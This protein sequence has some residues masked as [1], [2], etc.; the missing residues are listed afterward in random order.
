MRQ[1]PDAR[2]AA[3]PARPGWRVAV[4]GS[5]VAGL[6]AAWSLRQSDQPC[7][8]TLFEAGAHFGGHAH[9]QT[10]TLEGIRHGVDTGF[11]VYNE[12][13][14]PRLIRLFD[15]LAVATAPSDMSFSVQVHQGQ[16]RA[17]EWSGSNLATVFAQKRNLVRPRFW[18]ML[19]DIVRF[20]RLATALA[21][22]QGDAGMTQSV[23]DFLSQHGFGARFRDDYLLPMIGCIWSCPLDQML[24]FPMATLIRFCH[25][26]GLLQV[27]NRPQWYTVQGGSRHYVD[28]IVA[29][30]DDARLHTPVLA[31][32][33]GADGVHVH[34]QRG[35]EHFDA[36]VLAC[37]PDQALRLLGEGA[38]AQERAVLGAIRYQA[39][40]AVLHTDE[41]QLPQSRS[42]WAAWNY[43]R[44]TSADATQS[45]VCLHYLLNRLQPLPWTTP[46]IVTLNPVR[47]IDAAHVHARMHYE[48][49]VFDASAMA[50]Q[51]QVPQLQGQQRSWFC[52]AWCGYGFHEDGLRSGQQAAASLLAA[53]AGRSETSAV[54]V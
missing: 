24:Q 1:A 4:I 15:E 28:K 27:A 47:P 14:Y 37:H 52:G 31:L 10:L 50:A 40:L 19:A 21:Q 8:V 2:L 25:N 5:G 16:G 42:A 3:G 17:L 32:E 7:A 43:E 36:V 51:A 49:P 29:Q 26:H 13:T 45:P 22:A 41:A 46:V 53:L 30:L 35:R 44:N 9:T 54:A 34:S 23:A 38:S 48:H 12:R 18:G 20:N 33:R 11:L 6:G 39:N